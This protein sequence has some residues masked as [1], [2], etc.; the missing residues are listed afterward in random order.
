MTRKREAAMFYHRS[1]WAVAEDEFHM[2]DWN[3]LPWIMQYK[4]NYKW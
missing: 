2:T 4:L 1:D 3:I